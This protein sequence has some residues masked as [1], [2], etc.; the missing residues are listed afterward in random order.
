MANRGASD[1]IRR[2]NLTEW[3]SM[4]LIAELQDLPEWLFATKKKAY[5]SLTIRG[6]WSNK[7]FVPILQRS[8]IFG[9]NIMTR[10]IC[11]LEPVDCILCVWFIFRA[12]QCRVLFL[13][14][15]LINPFNVKSL[16]KWRNI[17]H[18]DQTQDGT[19]WVVWLK[20]EEDEEN[21]T[22]WWYS[23]VRSL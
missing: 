12:L 21:V 6:D 17:G 15:L 19:Q 13:L 2:E 8:T 16:E 9:K 20:E 3:V 18:I 11:M 1:N 4:W 5:Q 10:K 7:L 23:P 22:I 14:R